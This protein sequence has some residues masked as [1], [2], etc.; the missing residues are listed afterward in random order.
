MT[1]L[2]PDD[3][4]T[5]TELCK[6]LPGVKPRVLRRELKEALLN[7]EADG[8]S[9]GEMFVSKE[10]LRE[11]FHPAM[12]GLYSVE[13][14]SPKGAQILVRLYQ[15]GVLTKKPPQEI[16]AEV[17]E[18]ANSEAALRAKQRARIDA[19]NAFDAKVANPETIK[20]VDFSYSLLNAVFWKQGLK[21]HASMELDGIQVSK[22]VLA[23]HSNSGKS[24]DHRVVF[25]WIG[26]DGKEHRLEK[27][28]VYEGN[29]RNDPER[30]WGLP[31]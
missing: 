10:E 6:G 23:Y 5:F 16:S 4:K 31:E 17:L 18:Y 22:S 2:N 14:V 12:R 24:R 25:S 20:E 30:N 3:F 21:G 28:S 15:A 13:T 9:F 29:R 26:R 8:I 7:L 19:K 11:F 1:D 27:S